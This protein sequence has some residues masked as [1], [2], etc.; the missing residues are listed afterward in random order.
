MM[1]QRKK[2]KPE[3]LADFRWLGK[4]E[5]LQKLF[6][7]MILPEYKRQL[8]P[9]CI[10]TFGFKKGCTVDDIVGLMREIMVSHSRWKLNEEIHISSQDILTAFDEM[11]HET[12]EWG[13]KAS[14]I[15]AH[16]RAVMMRGLMDMT[17]TMDVPQV[18]M[19]DIVAML[20]AGIQGGA[21]TPEI[22]KTIIEAILET[23]IQMW[24]AIGFGILLNDGSV[25]TALVWAD[26]IWLFATNVQDMAIMT[27]QL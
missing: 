19:T 11:E 17:L 12:I 6:H 13:M 9:T 14:G 2:L 25:L 15:S 23:V 10:N 3:T 27:Q 22:F 24:L 18:G 26:N 8:N 16:M 21:A 5:V 1:G 7:R 4:S 20:K